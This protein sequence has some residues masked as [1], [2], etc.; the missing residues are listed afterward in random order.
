MLQFLLCYYTP[1]WVRGVGRGSCD[2]GFLDEL[3]SF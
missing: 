3:S 2:I 1:V